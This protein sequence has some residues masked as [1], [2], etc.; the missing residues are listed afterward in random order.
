MVDAGWRKRAETL[1][2]ERGADRLDHPGGTLLGHVGRVC[3]LLTEWGHD[4]DLQ[5]AGL[6]HACYGTDGFGFPL[7]PLDERRR[8]VDVI[9]ARAERWV[10]RYASCDRKTTYPELGSRGKVALT[11]RFTGE[12]LALEED[13]SVFV[14]LTAANELDL[15]LVNPEIAAAWGPGMLEL[16]RGARHWMSDAA[17]TAW[18]DAVSS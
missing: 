11:D 14:E 15:V 8:L 18:T 5:A 16:L 2:V 1:M 12:T 10:Y 9:G 13:A 7:L 3:D 4:E 6:C 17:W